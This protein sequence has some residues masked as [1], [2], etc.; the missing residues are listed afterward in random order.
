MLRS[1][2]LER[3]E[4]STRLRFAQPVLP[5]RAKITRL[6]APSAD[7]HARKTQTNAER[8]QNLKILPS[9]FPIFL[10]KSFDHSRWFG[11][12]GFSWSPMSGPCTGHWIVGSVP[13]L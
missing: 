13:G 3:G 7:D 10:P 1:E 11:H 6:A 5:S 2:F 9:A 4:E 8:N 12:S